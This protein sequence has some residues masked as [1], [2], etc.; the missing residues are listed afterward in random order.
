MRVARQLLRERALARVLTAY[1]L[2]C[3]AENAVWIA[4]V[5]YAYQRGGPTAA[6]LVAAAELLPA[7]LCAPWFAA[8]ADRFSPGRVLVVGYVVQAAGCAVMAVAAVVDGPAALVYAGAILASTFVA[9][10]RP[11]Q[12]AAL[13]ALA[14]DVAGLTA[15]NVAVAWL[16]SVGIVLGGLLVGVGAATVGLSSVFWTAV[17]LLAIAAAITVPV[18]VAPISSRDDVGGAWHD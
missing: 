10:T 4:V 17:A 7:A 3:V 16:E 14:H 1:A 8:A 12:T 9:A 11:A 5:I 18:H 2:F 6:G 13:P 15:A